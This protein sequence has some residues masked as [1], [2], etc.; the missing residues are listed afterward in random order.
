LID[1]GERPHES[2][3][4]EPVAGDYREALPNFFADDL[5][6]A[7]DMDGLLFGLAF[8]AFAGGL[9]RGLGLGL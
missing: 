1:G 8:A 6:I 4:G 3:V 5:Y 2:V 7:N 9:L